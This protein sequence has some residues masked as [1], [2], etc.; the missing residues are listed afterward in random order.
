MRAGRLTLATG[1]LGV[2]LLGCSHG[3]A[4]ADLTEG[5][6]I[7]ERFRQLNRGSVWRKV[8]EIRL[9]FRTHHPQGMTI[10]GDRL[11]LSS[12]EVLDRGAGRG[13]GHLFE[14][15][16]Q[17][18]LLRQLQLG[19][20]AMY[21]PGGID[22]D[23]RWIWV[24]V[25]EYRPESRSVVYRV[26]PRSMEAVK[27]FGFADHLGALVYDGPRR[28]LV[29]VSWGSRW[30]YRWELREAGG[31]PVSPEAPVRAVNGSHYVDYQDGQSLPGTSHALFGGISRLTA[32]GT[33]AVILGGLELVELGE[34]RPVWQLP[35]GLR[36][37][38]G[39]SL[40]RNPFAVRAWGQGLRFYFVPEDDVSSLHVYSVE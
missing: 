3:V 11:F 29:G 31:Q 19:E 6:L 26:D 23:G 25:A 27:V 12:V 4:L 35:V 39:E 28:A 34:R 24:P 2:V 33:P 21:H 16:F 5:S 38:G 20:G 40:L 10:V 15:D 14:V 32:E 1:W 30:F 22:F 37:A 8:D 36:A 17:G 9:D 13:V 7:A 18:K